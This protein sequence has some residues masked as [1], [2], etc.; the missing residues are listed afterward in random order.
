MVWYQYR[1]RQKRPKSPWNWSELCRWP[2]SLTT[3]WPLC[4]LD[5]SFFYPQCKFL[6]LTITR[7]RGKTASFLLPGPYVN[8]NDYWIPSLS[9][10][11]LC[12]LVLLFPLSPSTSCQSTANWE[13]PQWGRH[14]QLPTISQF[15]HLF[16]PCCLSPHSTRDDK[17]I[18]SLLPHPLQPE[19]GHEIQP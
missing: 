15:S 6:K 8:L 3:F 4:S 12:E 11:A 5:Y 14:L 13:S 7:Y 10:K 18:K 9:H 2:N 1:D 16:L 17:S 19:H